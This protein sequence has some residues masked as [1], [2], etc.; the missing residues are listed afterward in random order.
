M[1]T[2]APHSLDQ[3]ARRALAAALDEAQARGLNV[4]AVEIEGA[5][6]RLIL[7]GQGAQGEADPVDAWMK[8]NDPAA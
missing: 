6:V 1:T 2:P 4:A 5:K 7:A 3:R 8:A